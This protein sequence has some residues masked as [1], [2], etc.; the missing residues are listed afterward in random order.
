MLKKNSNR[1]ATANSSAINRPALEGTLERRRFD[2]QAFAKAVIARVTAAAAAKIDSIA[3]SA[4]M[5]V[6]S[7]R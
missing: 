5:W 7:T 1:D 2:V 4:F 3:G 6:P